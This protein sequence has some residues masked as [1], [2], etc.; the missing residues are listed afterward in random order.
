MLVGRL[1]GPLT[2]RLVIQPAMAALFAVRAGLKD[3]RQGRK[4]Y[5]WKM[6]RNPQ[7]RRELLRLGWRDVRIVFLMAML[8]DGVYQ[9]IA[10]KWIYPVQ[11]LIVAV[12]L[13][14]VPYG[15]I[16]GPA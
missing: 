8:L 1:Q 14:L 6:V 3:A 13:A 15:V 12:F 16:R 10:F 2:L 4:P 7:L 9:V 11:A 5:L